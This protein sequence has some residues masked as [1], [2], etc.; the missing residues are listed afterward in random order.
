MATTRDYYD[1]LGVPTRRQ[2]RGD[3]ARLP[4]ARP[5]VAPRRQHRRRRRTSAS[6]RSTR[7]TRSS[8]TRSAARPTTRS[9]V[10]AWAARAP[11]GY[12]PFGG[13]QGFGDIFDAFFGGATAGGRRP[14]AAPP[15]RRRP[16]LR[17]ELTFDEAIH[18]AEKEISF[19]ALGPC[20]TCDGSGAEAGSSPIT[21]PQC[22][23]SGE[24]REVRSTML[25][26]MVNVTACGRC[27]GQRPD[28]REALPDLSRRRPDGAQ[29]H[30]ARDRP[31]GHRRRPPDPP[32]RR[33]R[34]GAA[35]RHAR[36]PVRRHPRRGAPAASSAT[37]RSSTYELRALD[38]PGGAGCAGAHR[39][40]RRRGAARDQAGHPARHGDPPPRQGRAAPAPAGRARRPPRARRRR[41]AHPPHRAPARAARGARGRESGS[42][43]A[44]GDGAP[45]R[46]GLAPRKGKRSLGDRLK[47]AIS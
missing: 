19:T 6:R 14:A 22:D 31:G 46:P 29:A 44:D 33:G 3:Q 28:R 8:P 26:Q 15:G 17:P 21:C 47:D 34:G 9:G 35:R 16:A 2:R 40:A 12:G 30:A 24:V 45:E 20:E 42:S 4:Q 38:H 32:H 18:G 25:G 23:G 39:H 11:E 41:G 36:Q 27:R 5:A 7:P 1:I 43:S 10:P 37:T 13:F